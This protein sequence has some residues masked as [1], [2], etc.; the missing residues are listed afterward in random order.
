MTPHFWLPGEYACL[1]VIYSN[2]EDMHYCTLEGDYQDHAIFDGVNGSSGNYIIDRTR[3]LTIQKLAL[4]TF[5]A[6]D[7]LKLKCFAEADLFC[8]PDHL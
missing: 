8:P 4:R 5:K 1:G 2:I 3:T 6:G 7:V